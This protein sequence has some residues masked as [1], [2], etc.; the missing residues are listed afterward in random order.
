MGNNAASFAASEASLGAAAAAFPPKPPRRCGA[1]ERRCVVQWSA[2]AAAVSC[3]MSRR[4][5]G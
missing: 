4:V 3:S 2:R 5:R 1:T